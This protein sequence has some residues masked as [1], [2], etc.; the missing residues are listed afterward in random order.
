MKTDC[1]IK[2]GIYLCQFHDREAGFKIE[3]RVQN[4]SYL[5]L[6]GALDYLL[7]IFIKYTEI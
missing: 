2:L 1:C 6:A 3:R 7:T 4:S 5:C